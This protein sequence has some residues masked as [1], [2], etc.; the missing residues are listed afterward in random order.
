MAN[1]STYF[2][3]TLRLQSWEVQIVADE[4]SLRGNALLQE[5]NK[6]LNYFYGTDDSFE[7]EQFEVQ[8]LKKLC[9]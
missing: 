4:I 9:K 8:I 2:P 7:L 6:I 3:R 1:K 5:T